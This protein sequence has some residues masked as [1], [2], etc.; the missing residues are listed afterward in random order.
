MR[1]TCAFHIPFIIEP[2]KY[3]LEKITIIPNT[4][5]LFKSY[6]LYLQKP[7]YFVLLF[8]TKSMF[9]TIITLLIYL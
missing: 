3:A 8:H 2:K 7:K 6:I 9:Y 4:H 1:T 5:F